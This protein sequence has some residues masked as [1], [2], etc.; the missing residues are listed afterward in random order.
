MASF[1][2]HLVSLGLAARTVDTYRRE[3]ATVEEWCAAHGH[4][5]ARIGPGAVA[6]YLATRPASYA[7]RRAIRAALDHY[8][9]F[10]NRRQP[11]LGA[12]RVPPQPRMVCRALDDGDARILAKAA[13]R[14]GDAPGLAVAFGLYLGLRRA[15]VAGL[16]WEAFS[17]GWLRVV[18]K[19]EVAA[20]LP[21]HPVVVALLDERPRVSP[22]VFPGRFGGPVTPATVWKWTKEVAEQAGVGSMTC[23]QLRH[24]CLATA[25]DA[26]GDL[27]AVQAF[28]R[29][30]KPETTA[31]YTR[32][33]ARRLTAVM[34]AIDYG[35]S[36]GGSVVGPP[37]GPY[38]PP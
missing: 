11:P 21:V 19:G 8:W 7:T 20:V 23:H 1:Y 32:A 34:E 28:A 10:T 15:E 25:N 16:R 26:T 27:R 31:G 6:D 33:T 22:W 2:D 5:L 36:N 24:T 13:E 9:H 12:I 37:E 35:D 14:R 17:G 29:H 38:A 4:S 3:V 18:G 30:A